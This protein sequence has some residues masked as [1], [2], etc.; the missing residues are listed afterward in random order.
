MPK[1][2]ELVHIESVMNQIHI[3]RGQRI[4]LDTDLADLYGVPTKRFN[5]QVKRNEARFPSDFMF[6]LSKEEFDILR[7]QFVIYRS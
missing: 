1:N 6:Q 3:I 4:V 2:T 7:S 5:E